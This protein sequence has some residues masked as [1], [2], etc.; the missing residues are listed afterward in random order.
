[1][2]KTETRSNGDKLLLPVSERIKNLILGVHDPEHPY[3]SKSEAVFAV[4]IAMAGAGCA[5]EAMEAICLD[6]SY[7]ISAH[8]LA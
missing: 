3:Q 7:P 2:A 8:V 6:P 5:D 4:L 1:M